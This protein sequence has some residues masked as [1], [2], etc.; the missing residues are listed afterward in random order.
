MLRVDT[1]VE[2]P[3]SQKRPQSTAGFIYMGF[4]NL[5]PPRKV[6]RLGKRPLSMD[7]KS[8]EITILVYCC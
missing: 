2:G 1:S 4:I 7:R 6:L 8:S 5:H 3:Q